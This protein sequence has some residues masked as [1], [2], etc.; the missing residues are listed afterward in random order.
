MTRPSAP[1]SAVTSLMTI[2]AL[3]LPIYAAEPIAAGAT[4]IAA[5]E[6]G[7]HIVAFSSQALDENGTLV[8]GWDGVPGGGF[9]PS[10]DWEVG[11]SA[12][13]R[14]ALQLPDNWQSGPLHLVAG[15]YNTATGERLWSSDGEDAVFIGTLEP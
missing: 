6:N 8:A 2:V 9:A 14:V 4:N 11:G 15:M 7:G 1:V 12:I 5:A 3:A 13:D 10:M